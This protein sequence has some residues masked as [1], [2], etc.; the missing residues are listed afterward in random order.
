MKKV[1]VLQTKTVTE[2]TDVVRT[3][4]FTTMKKAVEHFECCNKD[5]T[6]IVKEK[7]ELTKISK[8]HY[9][10]F[11]HDSKERFFE[12]SIYEEAVY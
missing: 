11:G 8:T 5:I 9:F 3:M 1:A 10:G 2:N 4:I 7:F 6:G 12:V